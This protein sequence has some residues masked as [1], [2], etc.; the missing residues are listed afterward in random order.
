MKSKAKIVPIGLM[1]QSPE[2]FYYSESWVFM[3]AKDLI[4]FR[5]HGREEMEETLPWLPALFQQERT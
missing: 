2:I 1:M 5:S 4:N 3:E